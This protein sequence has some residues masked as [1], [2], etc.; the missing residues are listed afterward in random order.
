MR[1]VIVAIVAVFCAACA[2]RDP[3]PASI[4]QPQD[5]T[6]DCAMIQAEIA[7]NNRRVQRACR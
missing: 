6:M 1:A 7:A 2:G 5:A 3:Q 4:T